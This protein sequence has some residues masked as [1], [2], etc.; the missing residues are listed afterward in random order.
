[1]GGRTNARGDCDAETGPST[2]GKPRAS[3]ETA[4]QNT[5]AVAP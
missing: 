1:M 2:V 4:A 5:V 3:D